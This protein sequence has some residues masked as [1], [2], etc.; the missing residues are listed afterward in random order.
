MRRL[1]VEEFTKEKC[2]FDEAV[3]RSPGL[4]RFCS[5]SLWQLAALNCL[6]APGP[7]GEHFIV[8]DE[9][10]WLLFA[11]GEGNRI[12]YPFEAAWMFGSPL[13]GDPLRGV[14]LLKKAAL[15]YLPGRVGFCF[16]GVPKGGI[17]H[18]ALQSRRGEFLRYEEFPATDC[19]MIDLGAGFEAW[20]EGRSRKF[21]KSIRQLKEDESIDIIDAGGE[22]SQSL[23]DRIL[24]IQKQ[25]YKWEEGTDIFLG[26]DYRPF[27][28]SLLHGLQSSN[29]LRLLF[30]R[31]DGEDLAYIFGGVRGKAYRG[32]QMGYIESERKS[33]LGNRLQVAN[34]KARAEEGVTVY[35]L[36]MHAEYKERWADRREEFVGAFMVL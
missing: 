26:N 19:M 3:E 8:E 10:D 16:G 14:D 30:A 4:A 36:G 23:F 29:D 32:F 22:D 13:V 24:A 20:L 34:L 6:K 25:T 33:G 17:L 5:S 2:Y 12:F 27:Y 15:E 1:S 31:R 11:E 35:D 9:G 18:D 21:R 7:R 28:R